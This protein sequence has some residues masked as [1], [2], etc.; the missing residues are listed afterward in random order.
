MRKARYKTARYRTGVILVILVCTMLCGCGEKKAI[1]D[2]T[3]GEKESG[4]KGS[5]SVPNA[6][7]YSFDEI[8]GKTISLNTENIIVPE[9]DSMKTVYYEEVTVDNAYKQQ[10]AEHIFEKD[11]G[12]YVYDGS[13]MSDDM[14][15]EMEAYYQKCI[16]IATQQNDTNALSMYNDMFA[17]IIEKKAS[18]KELEAAGNYDV[19]A[20]IGYINDRL[21]LLDFTLQNGGFELKRYAEELNA[22]MLSVENVTYAIAYTQYGEGDLVQTN[23]LNVAT[24]GK[25][26][27]AAQAEDFLK[28]IGI[29]DAEVVETAAS[30][31]LCYDLVLGQNEPKIVYD[32]YYITF[33]D[34]VDGYS[35]YIGY[36]DFVESLNES[37]E[38]KEG[39]TTQTYEVNI[40]DNG[41]IGVVCHDNYRRTGKVED[42][43]LLAWDDMLTVANDNIKNYYSNK[44]LSG[45][46]TFNYVELSYYM[47]KLKD[48][49]Y[50]L[51][52]VWVFLSLD[53]MLI[54][55]HS[56][57][58][59][60]ELLIIDAE[61]GIP[62]DIK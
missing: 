50:A 5:L 28:R 16:D 37:G 18:A 34:T 58:Y 44:K 32:G 46:I 33:A 40:N 26:E 59:P 52:P 1:Y 25:E 6:D 53:D 62:I 15:A 61:N 45:N 11:K 31:W 9:T 13:S 56:D 43:K 17:E 57:V 23:D 7:S 12:I 55:Y 51:K 36:F 21:F 60:N 2:A 8:G 4:L 27:M 54:T 30:E 42:T 39:L 19:D 41:I 24:L 35:P 48:G 3:L 14:L 29:T 47:E 22:E 20:Y 49:S 38:R 10:I